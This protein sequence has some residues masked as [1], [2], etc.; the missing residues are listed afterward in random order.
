MASEQFQFLILCLQIYSSSEH[1][2]SP[3]FSSPNT[4]HPFFFLLKP[5]L[6]YHILSSAPISFSGEGCLS[7]YMTLAVLRLKWRGKQL[8]C[9]HTQTKKSKCFGFAI[10][11]VLYLPQCFVS[12]PP[13]CLFLISASVLDNS[14]FHRHAQICFQV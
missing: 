1:N 13:G 14:D 11:S 6:E 7:T 8:V 5:N 9:V 4:S 3:F 10:W 2:P 12:L